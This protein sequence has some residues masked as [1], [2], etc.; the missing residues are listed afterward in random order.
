MTFLKLLFITACCHVVG[1]AGLSAVMSW[2]NGES[3]VGSVLFSPL[4]ALAG[5]PMAFLILLLVLVMWGIYQQGG[6][7]PKWV[8]VLVGALVGAGIGAFFKG[9]PELRWRLAFMVGGSL[10]GMLSNLLIVLS[11]NTAPNEG[12]PPNGGP[13]TPAGD[14]GVAEGPPSV[15]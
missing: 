9:G 11:N 13:A 7:R 10:A 14:S 2:P 8:F 6:I 3:V 1:T 12:A 15:S 5:W 4:L